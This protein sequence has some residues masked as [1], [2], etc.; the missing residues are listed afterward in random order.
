MKIC[1]TPYLEHISIIISAAAS[2]LE[3][4]FKYTISAYGADTA[5]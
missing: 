4:H 2:V 1:F 3:H 5:I